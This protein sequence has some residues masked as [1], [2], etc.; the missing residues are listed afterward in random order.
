M[1]DL[2]ILAKLNEK[3]ANEPGMRKWKGLDAVKVDPQIV[4]FLEEHPEVFRSMPVVALREAIGADA[5]DS[6]TLDRMHKRLL[7]GYKS[8]DPQWKK[9]VSQITPI[10]DFRTRY[11][12]LHG[13]FD[14]LSQVEPSGAYLEVEFSDDQI[15]YT[16]AKYGAMFAY[17]FEAQTYDDL[18]LL[19]T[20][21]EKFGA[22]AAR[23]I[24]YFV[25]YTCMD[26][27]PT[28]YDGT[29]NVFSSAFSNTLSTA[30]LNYERLKEA[31][32]TMLS[33]TDIDSNAAMFIPKFLVVHPAEAL[34][35]AELVES[36][37]NPDSGD[38]AINALKNKLTV[39]V[40]PYITS[41]NW[42]LIA[43][44]AQADTFEIGL[45][46]GSAE[47]ELFYEPTNSGHAFEYDEIRLKVR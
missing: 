10:N 39:I 13:S 25:F 6:I 24:D 45:W 23:T 40:T 22:A 26:A 47:P 35:A 38:N 27:N 3:T 31:Y 34:R 12:I 30:G 20:K 8:W 19:D 18:G 33:Q 29:N 11:A 37:L 44:P 7:K 2:G 9:V 1:A 14:R 41:T 15:T 4:A 28:S 5:F 46:K 32:E 43:D 21:A 42:Y 36:T 17:T 16:P